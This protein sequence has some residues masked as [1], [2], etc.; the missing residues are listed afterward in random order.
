MEENAAICVRK[1]TYMAVFLGKK[2]GQFISNVMNLKIYSRQ[3]AR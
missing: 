1:L 3:F 2:F